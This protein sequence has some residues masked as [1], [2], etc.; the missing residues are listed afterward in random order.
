MLNGVRES[1]HPGASAWDVSTSSFKT[2]VQ[3]FI[4]G[5]TLRLVGGFITAEINFHKKNSMS[6]LF[7][8]RERRDDE[9]LHAPATEIHIDDLLTPVNSLTIYRWGYPLILGIMDVHIAFP[10]FL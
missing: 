2:S 3:R 10:S 7:A 1:A 9:G 4:A 6:R 8:D 5:S